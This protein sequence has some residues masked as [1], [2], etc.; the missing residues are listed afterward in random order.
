MKKRLT[1]LLLTAV[2]M[3]CENP[4]TKFLVNEVPNN[5][6]IDF[7]QQLVPENKLIHKGIF[8]PDLD[9]YYYTISDQN[10]EQFNVYVIK[11]HNGKW[12][13]PTNAF[14]DSQYNEH[15]MSFSPDGN[16]LYFSS[17]R[18][19]NI[20]GIP[21]TW[22]IWKSDKV[23]GKWQE[24]IFVDIPNLRNKLVSHPTITNA[25]TLYFHVSNLDYSEMDIY[26]AT[27]IN[28]NYSNAEKTSISDNAKAGRCTPYI[29]PKEDYLIFAA[30]GDPLELMI[31]FSDGNGGWNNT[32]KLN[33]D[34]NTNGQ[35]NPYV[36]PDNKF[37]FFT[38]G[39]SET[40]WSVKWVDIE[41]ELKQ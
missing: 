34:I 6:P 18:P 23:N 20:P 37:L 9:A 2:I 27:L 5:I 40:K 29:S 19:V 14:F 26:H 13:E 41:S 8:S 38:T 36:T 21:Q 11:K 25:G 30:I 22:H 35:G 31:S 33:A 24:P 7:K 32:K 17:T 10:F 1:I 16:S 12:S 39:N 28:G 3:S 4:K 15:G